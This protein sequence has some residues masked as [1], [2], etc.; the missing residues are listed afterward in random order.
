MLKKTWKYDYAQ[1]GS[2]MSYFPWFLSGFLKVD[3]LLTRD[4]KKDKLFGELII[5][6]KCKSSASEMTEIYMKGTK[7]NI[8]RPNDNE[9]KVSN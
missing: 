2:E 5:L 8:S 1:V 4:P 7:M 3:F 6:W 9:D